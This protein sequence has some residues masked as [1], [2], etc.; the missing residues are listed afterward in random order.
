[1][2]DLHIHYNLDGEPTLIIG[3]ASDI[4][5]EVTLILITVV[6][7]CKYFGT[8]PFKN[9]A[10]V[11]IAGPDVFI[12][13]LLEETCWYESKEG[14]VIVCWT[15]KIFSVF[16]GSK[17]IH[18]SLMDDAVLADFLPLGEGYVAYTSQMR[19]ALTPINKANKDA[20][21]V[22]KVLEMENGGKTTSTQS[23]MMRNMPSE[24]MDPLSR[25][26]SH[27]LRII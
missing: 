6:A 24:G 17:M 27:S 12:Q 1:L 25:L 16:F 5:G 23:M 3:N 9:R 20:A 21:V 19:A 2:Y 8:I 14:A 18:G 15:P 4:Q 11:G 13:A 26:I 22:I 10:P 7:T